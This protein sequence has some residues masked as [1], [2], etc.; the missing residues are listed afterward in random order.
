MGN[1][2][3]IQIGE[4]VLAVGSPFGDEFIST[5]TAGIVSAKGRNINIIRDKNNLQIESF[6]Q[7]DAVVNPGNSGGPLVNVRGELVGINTAIATPTGTYA[8]YSFAIPSTLVKKVVADLKEFGVVQRAL[9]N[10]RITDV[11]SE[12]AEKEELEVVE[13]V[14]VSEVIDVGAADDA[15]LEVGD[16]VVAIDGEQVTKTAELQEKVALHRPGDKIQVDLIRDGKKK[17][18]QAIL[19]NTLGT[20]KT[21]SSSNNFVIQGASFEYVSKKDKEKYEIEGGAKIVELEG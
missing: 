8:G 12:L 7:T 20:T 1:S 5:V 17:T 11:T 4:W 10:I 19:K 16:V 14:Y 6:I 2:D 18:V 15:G 21:V 9:L 13:G 3:K